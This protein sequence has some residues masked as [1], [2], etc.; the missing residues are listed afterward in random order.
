M[1][2]ANLILST[3]LFDFESIIN[4]RVSESVDKAVN[5]NNIRVDEID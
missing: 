1:T 5:F 3:I 2:H 4:Q